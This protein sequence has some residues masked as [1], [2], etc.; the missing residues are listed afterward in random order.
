MGLAV[1]NGFTLPVAFPIVL[2][3]LLL[4][5][6]RTRNTLGIIQDGWPDLYN[7][8]GKLLEMDESDGTLEDILARSYTFNIQ[9]LDGRGVEID[10]MRFSPSDDSWKAWRDTYN[11]DTNSK[12]P[13]MITFENRVDF[14]RDYIYW[15]VFLSVYNQTQDFIK[16]FQSCF[17]S[18][19]LSTLTPECLRILTEGSGAIDIEALQRVVQYEGYTR[20]EPIIREFWEIVHGYTPERLKALLKF[21]TASDR[22]PAT[23]MENLRFKIIR[24][25]YR[26]SEVRF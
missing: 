18:H 9:T 15:L 17:G 8:L 16:G 12:E 24:S 2:Y 20:D 6:T 22:V 25:G 26:N 23:G 1:L 13:P 21:V 3:R 5:K 7:S 4:D 14:V 19:T 10:M 11:N